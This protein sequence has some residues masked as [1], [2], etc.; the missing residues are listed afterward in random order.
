MPPGRQGS[1]GLVNEISSRHITALN[2]YHASAAPETG[3]STEHPDNAHVNR[4]VYYN[5]FPSASGGGGAGH[6]TQFNGHFYNSF[7]VNSLIYPRDGTE[8]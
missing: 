3:T 5:S 2:P 4:G 1:L 6:S 8:L 7:S